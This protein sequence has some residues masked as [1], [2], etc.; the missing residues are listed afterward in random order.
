MRAIAARGKVHI[1]D[2]G[3]FVGAGSEVRQ[4]YV[5]VASDGVRLAGSVVFGDPQRSRFSSALPL[6]RELGRDLMFGQLAS[7]DVYFTGLAILNPND[8]V[9]NAEVS[10]YDAEGQVLASKT[11]RVEGKRRRSGC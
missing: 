9:V 1:T 4:G 6:V 8:G 11:E 5:E 2:Q 10:V 7:N 3:F